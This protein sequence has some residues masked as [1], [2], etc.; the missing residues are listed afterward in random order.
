LSSLGRGA[1]EHAGEKGD[2]MRLRALF[3]A[4]PLAAT[5]AVTA[6]AP[7][8]VSA[9]AA[10]WS[11]GPTSE[12]IFSTP[13]SQEFTRDIYSPPTSTFE[14]GTIT[15]TTGAKQTSGPP[16]ITYVSS[17]GANGWVLVVA[18][19]TPKVTIRFVKG[20]TSIRVDLHRFHDGN[21]ATE[22]A[23]GEQLTVCTR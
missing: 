11:C 9:S 7:Q 21:R 8:V 23:I 6:L 5:M 3:I 4:G 18:I 17:T 15:A 2:T 10:T 16:P 14:I 1:R 22:A 13:F 20:T 19:T 12:V